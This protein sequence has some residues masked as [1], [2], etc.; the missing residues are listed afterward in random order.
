MFEVHAK[1]DGKGGVTWDR[2]L[3]LEV[4]KPELAK[5]NPLINL[6]FLHNKKTGKIIAQSK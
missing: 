1:D 5:I 4:A 6:P 2:S 3:W